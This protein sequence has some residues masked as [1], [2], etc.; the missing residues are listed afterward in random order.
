MP[1][2]QATMHP[3]AGY[4]MFQNTGFDTN[5]SIRMLTANFPA[6]HSE[7]DELDSSSSEK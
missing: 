3:T 2:M 1:H 4:F 6:S 5:R 7:I